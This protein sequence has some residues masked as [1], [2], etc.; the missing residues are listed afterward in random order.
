MLWYGRVQGGFTF[1]RFWLSI[2]DAFFWVPGMRWWCLGDSRG[3]K[4]V[5]TQTPTWKWPNPVS[6]SICTSTPAPARAAAPSAQ[7]WA[8]APKGLG[9]VGGLLSHLILGPSQAT[10]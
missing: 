4:L 3:W 10:V 9:V 6:S 5:W 2:P 8:L 1:S 7:R